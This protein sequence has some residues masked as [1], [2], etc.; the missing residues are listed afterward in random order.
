M[1]PCGA[2]CVLAVSSSLPSPSRDLRA[3]HQDPISMLDG[4]RDGMTSS[5]D[6]LS[7]DFKVP[8]RRTS[9][10][11]AP[12]RRCRHLLP[13]SDGGHAV[14]LSALPFQ[15]PQRLACQ[16]VGRCCHHPRRPWGSCRAAG[17][18]PL[19]VLPTLRH[20]LP[21]EVFPSPSAASS[22]HVRRLAL[23]FASRMEAPLSP[24]TRCRRLFSSCPMTRSVRTAWARIAT[25]GCCSDGESVAAPPKRRC[26]LL[27]WAC[28]PVWWLKLSGPPLRGGLK[29]S[30]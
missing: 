6:F 20:A 2:R 7:W 16:S 25:S 21:F 17:P 8:L 29:P 28:S 19:D 5:A 26:P 12:G 9:A 27:P 13:S 23:A 3:H 15:R 18:P 10:W 11:P 24:L 4:L 30:G 22:S 14:S 1:A